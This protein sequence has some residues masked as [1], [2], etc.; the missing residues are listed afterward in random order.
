MILYR[1]GSVYL[2]CTQ[3][4]LTFEYFELNI[5]L[6]G[7]LVYWS[8]VTLSHFP[9]DHIFGKICIKWWK[10]LIRWVGYFPDQ[11]FYLGKGLLY[12]DNRLFHEP[13][14]DYLG[15][16]VILRGGGILKIH[17]KT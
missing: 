1:C 7:Q 8:V 3:L 11:K 17:T 4:S 13:C 5:I 15:S 2:K 10:I 14:I 16:V 9:K 6:F 12:E